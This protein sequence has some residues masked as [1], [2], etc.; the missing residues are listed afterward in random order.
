MDYTFPS[1]V[2]FLSLS[3]TALVR[4]YFKMK[5]DNQIKLDKS[6]LVYTVTFPTGTTDSMIQDW[7]RSVGADLIPNKGDG[8]SV[9]TVVTEVRW[10]PKGIRHVLRVTPQDD[11]HVMSMLEAHIPGV[12]Y[13][14]VDTPEESVEI[15]PVYTVDMVMSDMTKPLSIS[16]AD[17]LVRSIL[18]SVPPLSEGEQVAYQVILGHAKRFATVGSRR[19]VV[20]TLIYGKIE[21]APEDAKIMEQRASQARL[22][23]SIRIAVQAPSEIRG[24][25][26]AGGLI[27]S[28]RQANSSRT[29]FGHVAWS[30]DT[31]DVISSALTPGGKTAQLI[32]PEAAALIAMP[33]GDPQAAGLTQGAARRLQA[34]EAISS[35]GEWLLG[36]NDI[37]GR[38]KPITLPKEFVSQ[39]V[40][41]VGAPGSGKSTLLQNGIAHYAEAGLGIFVI[42]AG[43]DVSTQRLFYRALDA[44]PH[45]RKDDVICI[46]PAGDMDYPVSINILDQDFGMAA[47]G[48]VKDVIESIFHDAS[49]GTVSVGQVIQNGLWTLIEAGGYTLA[50]LK[51]LIS[52]QNAAEGA[53]SAAMIRGVK[54]PELQDFWAR[55]PGALKSWS[56]N[57]GR[58]DWNEYIKPTLRRIWTITDRPEIRHLLGQSKSTVKIKDAMQQ[59]KILLFSVGGMDDP[60]AASIISSLFTQMA[61]VAAQSITPT[62]P[63]VLFLDEFQ[64]SA[65]I[66]GGLPDMLARARALNLGLVLATQ[67]VTREDIPR[68]LQSAVYNNTATKIVFRSAS[69]E[70]E[71]WSREFGRRLVTDNDITR[72]HKYHAVAQVANA[73]GDRSPVTF[74]AY[75]P[76][77]DT[78]LTNHLLAQSRSRYGRHVDKVRHEIQERRRVQLAPETGKA[79][80]QQTSEDNIVRDINWQQ[81]GQDG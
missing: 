37:H 11:G 55:N 22:N 38:E 63:N 32:I 69:G 7:L 13:D 42:D 53:W 25:Q 8:G 60:E 27:K 57:S 54:D 30:G 33:S 74:K 1:S 4:W 76:A 36:H 59:N 67:F 15:Q 21:I 35:T 72:L 16:N 77:P 2:A 80:Q 70:A 17:A 44:M 65:N 9:P 29:G 81:E 28:L 56:D 18:T 51:P 39:H 12:I 6:R 26:L 50:D 23:A 47:I 19:G 46:N 66:Q 43:Q 52:P 58:R 5:H 68:Q 41:V 34:T 24:K 31:S 48:I 45:S 62:K 40:S 20:N 3:L 78:N 79:Y 71:K 73:T 14:P 10:T 64:V 49:K 61:W 75:R